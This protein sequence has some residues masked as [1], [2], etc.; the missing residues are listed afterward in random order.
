MATQA[1]IHN[2]YT[3]ALRARNMSVVETLRL[4]LA[5]L[6]NREI[7]KRGKTGA[8]ELSEEEVIEVVTREVKK[9]KE[10]IGLYTQGNRSDL[11][12]KEKKELIIIEKFLPPQMDEEEVRIII[13]KQIE[14]MG[15]PPASD[16]GKVM[17]I[18]MKDLKGKV[19]G[20]VVTKIIKE[21]LK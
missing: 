4:L 21:I 16:F 19:D 11:A 12:D 5:A 7:E 20:T 8:S 9:R 10:A 17:G 6:Q 14:T 15:N 3:E 13:Q 2:E 1:T 18:V